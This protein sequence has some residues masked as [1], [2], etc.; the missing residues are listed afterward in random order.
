MT[1]KDVIQVFRTIADLLQLQGADEFRVRSYQRAADTVRGLTEDIQ[2]VRAR[3]ELERLPGIGKAIAAK[4][5]ELLTT[6]Q[7]QFLVDLQAEIPAGLVQMLEVPELGPKTAKRLHEE[8]G[9]T[10]IAELEAAATA[11]RLR[12]LKGFGARS[13]EKLLANIALWRRGRERVLGAQALMVAEPLL[14]RLRAVPGVSAV[15]LAGSL[16]RGRDT[17]KDIDLLVAADAGAAV[18]EAFVTAPEVAEVVGRG[19][20]KAAVRLAGLNADLRVVPP[21][22]WGAAL[23]YFTGSKAHNIALR[24]RARAR[25]LTI[26]EYGV[27]ALDAGE[28]TPPVASA[29]EA[30]V[31][32]A[33][34]LPWIPPE[35]REDAGEFDAAEANTLPALLELGDLRGDLHV[36]SL[37]SD[38]QHAIAD[39]AVAARDLGYAY[40]AIT[41]HSQS[42]QVANGLDERRVRAQWDDIARAQE[43]VP[44]VR[45]LRGIEVDILTDG[46]LDLG[47]DL[48]AELDIVVASVHVAFQMDEARMTERLVRAVSS[49][50]VDV[51]G[52]PTGRLLCRREGF[53]FEFDTVVDA[54][55]AHGV[56][57]ELNAAPERLDLDE[58][59]ARR[60]RRRGA[61]IVLSTDAH[62][63]D[64][65]A[66]MRY[67]VMQARRAWLT[68]ADLLNT[69]RVDGLLE[70]LKDD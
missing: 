31:Y 7:V 27:F 63:T 52:H 13:E 11:Q 67:G 35:L 70:R 25:G 18:I 60:A 24:S 10:S 54:A 6:G 66:N 49:G 62:A 39:L 57:L 56:A 28:G 46:R 58:V 36:H 2:A 12:G 65:F 68:S 4:I 21:A 41:D 22:S 16:R 8:L 34:G 20:T 47:L 9:L 3:G 50:V 29:S 19:E 17:T 32:A 55:V 38:G 37:W 48:L 1:N 64:Q 59:M 26:N 5:D 23:Q 42:L 53:T 30:D 44:E 51:L 61:D 69:R 45:L 14:E 15:S 33:V 43:Q 40:L